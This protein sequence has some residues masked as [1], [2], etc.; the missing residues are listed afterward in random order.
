M[1][2]RHLFGGVK[3]ASGIVFCFK[4]IEKHHHVFIHRALVFFHWQNVVCLR[5]DNLLGDVAMDP[6]RLNGNDT[7]GDSQRRKQFGDRRDFIRFL[8][9]FR[10]PQ[11]HPVFSCPGTDHPNPGAFVLLILTA[12]QLF[13]IQ[14]YQL[15]CCQ[16]TDVL[17]PGNKL[18]LELLGIQPTKDPPE[19]VV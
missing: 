7:P 4:S 13:A 12:P 8:I 3:G 2:L 18:S 14:R 15:S 6:H 5:F 1:P 16:F 11:Y 17:C 9:D 10:L 19:G